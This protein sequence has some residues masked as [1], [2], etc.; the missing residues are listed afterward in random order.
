MKGQGGIGPQSVPG[1]QS[2]IGQGP[3]VHSQ[4]SRA[5]Q[6]AW[7]EISWQKSL[8]AGTQ[9]YSHLGGD[10]G[11]QVSVEP[12]G[13]TQPSAVQPSVIRRHSGVAAQSFSPRF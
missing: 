8:P 4:S 2:I 9:A 13:T 1:A 7:S 12:S 10:G 5:A 6:P 3:W 11:G